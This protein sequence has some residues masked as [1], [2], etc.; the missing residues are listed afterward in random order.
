MRAIMVGYVNYFYKD[1]NLPTGTKTSFKEHSILTIHSIITK[2]AMSFMHRVN[3]FPS[4]LPPS[5]LHT[6][7]ADIPTIGSDH[8][9]CT[10]WLIRYNS[11]SYRASLFFKGPLLAITQHFQNTLTV[12][13]YLSYKSHLLSTKKYMLNL[14]TAGTDEEWPNFL[15]YNIPGL[16]HSERASALA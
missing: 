4:S 16:R 3:G 6:I 13:S 2:N 10:E 9:S 7:P 15:L 1:G 8:T 12:S 11:L 14:Q 5:I